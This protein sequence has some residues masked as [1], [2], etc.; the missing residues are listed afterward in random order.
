MYD[1]IK[2]LLAK[3]AVHDEENANDLARQIVRKEDQLEQLHLHKQYCEKLTHELEM[4]QLTSDLN[5]TVA[6]ASKYLQK[7]LIESE[8]LTDKLHKNQ[9]LIE[10]LGDRRRE[11]HGQLDARGDDYRVAEVLRKARDGR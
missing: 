10:K 5:N 11:I 2:A 3:K 1:Q 9:F 6:K 4:N 7:G 8:G